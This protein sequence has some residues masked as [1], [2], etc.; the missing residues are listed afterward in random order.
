MVNAPESPSHVSAEA[1]SGGGAGSKK[2]PEPVRYLLGCLGVMLG[3]E[4]VHQILSVIAIVVDP[5]R[6][7][8]SARQAARSSNEALTE[9]L[10][11]ATVYSS[12]ALMAVFQL[13]V[14]ILLA[15]AARAVATRATWAPSALRLLQFFGV[16]FAIRAVFLFFVSPDSTTVPIALYAVDGIV[17]IVI[18]TAG[19]C[20]VA[21]AM[22]GKVHEYVRAQTP[23]GGPTNEKKK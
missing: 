18:G 2:L 7:R 16:F 6:L 9:E 11:N 12:V 23:G 21:Y 15:V 8:E 19:A 4:L 22:Q 10:L 14:L 13:I 20:A 3:G 1:V 5:S 17:Q